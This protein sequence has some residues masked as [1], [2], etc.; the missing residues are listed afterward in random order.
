MKKTFLYFL[1]V[2]N[3]QFSFAQ[4][5]L[6]AL[7]SSNMVLQ[8]STTV[9]LWG[10]AASNEKFTIEASW[11]SDIISV[12]A[13]KSGNWK[14]DIVTTDSKNSQKITFKSKG[15]PDLILDNILFGEVWI[16]SGQSNMGMP[17][18]GNMG[19]PIFG[20]T[21]AIANAAN[22][23]LRLFH[24]ERYGSKTPMTKLE[25]YRPWVEA[26]P[27]SVAD[28]S[29]AAY[30]FGEQL[31]RT[32]DVPVG[33]ISTSW[34][35]SFVQAWISG[36]VLSP[37]ESFD[38]A[39]ADPV[40]NGNKVPTVLF[41]AMINPLIPFTIKGAI[42]YQGESNRQDPEKYKELFPAMV[43]DWRTRWNVGDFPFYFVQIAPFTY[44][45]NNAFG[46][47]DN[48]A[49]MR[50]AQ[51]QCVDLI[52]NSGIVITTDIGDAVTIHPPKKKEV[53]QRLAFN[54]LKQTYGLASIDGASPRYE[55]MTVQED[56]IHLTFKNAESGLYA[57][58]D[59]EGFEM[60]GEDKVFYP[61]KANI[62]NNAREVLVS[63][64]QVTKPVA[65]RYAWQNMVVGTLFDT[66]LLPASC[67]RTD[68]WNDA[69]RAIE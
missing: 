29:A 2:L 69:T 44:G 56:G 1:I 65:V 39:D 10:W 49:F 60:A 57:F 51:V 17:I 67:F 28:F 14:T 20:S 54:A 50:E 34:G 41:N 12:I 24:V 47:L 27:A 52:P 37:L 61:A 63:A 42:W 9:Q 11:Q 58:G 53:G 31:Q 5:E 6:P 7:V 8:R 38:L 36:E 32:L 43:V 4:I 45:N 22:P 48:S 19:Q 30:F 23:N 46:D 33:L 68:D 21:E 15:N 66:S 64:D 3:A 62:I 55:A 40:K 16:C 13:D 26:S 35:G 59:L 18:K 25:K